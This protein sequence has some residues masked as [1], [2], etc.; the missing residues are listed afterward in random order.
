MCRRAATTTTVITNH[1]RYRRHRRHHSS[2][3]HCRRRSQLRPLLYPVI[4]SCH[5]VRSSPSRHHH[6][7][8]TII[9]LPWSLPAVGLPQ[10]LY[11]QTPPS[12]SSSS[13]PSRPPHNEPR[14]PCGGSSYPS[15]VK[16]DV[17]VREGVEKADRRFFRRVRRAQIFDLGLPA[18]NHPPVFSFPQDAASEGAPAAR[19]CARRMWR[20]VRDC[21]HGAG[22]WTGHSR[23]GV[24]RGRRGREKVSSTD[25]P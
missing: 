1:R 3:R 6:P 24:D 17:D 16:G 11:G 8:I 23:L 5:P 2:P 20:R 21:W 7:V 4:P 22:G 25:D 13:S 15:D 14:G 19:L 9:A 12:S 18:V 10:N